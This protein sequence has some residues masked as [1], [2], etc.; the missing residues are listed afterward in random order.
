MEIN[1][2]DQILQTSDVNINDAQIPTGHLSFTGDKNHMQDMFGFFPCGKVTCQIFERMDQLKPTDIGII[3]NILK[4]LVNAGLALGEVIFDRKL[5]EF[6]TEASQYFWFTVIRKLL[7]KKDTEEYSQLI[8]YLND[9][10]DSENDDHEKLVRTTKLYLAV[11][12]R[13]PAAVRDII[14]KYPARTDYITYIQAM[15][16]VIFPRAAYDE[17][18]FLITPVTLALKHQDEEMV[19]IFC[20]LNHF[21][22]KKKVTNQGEE[23]WCWGMQPL[24][25]RKI[26]GFCRRRKL[27]LC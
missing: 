23:A 6:C 19:N 18:P 5:G 20:K 16:G 15:P 24:V 21:I 3:T 7:I 9:T 27:S 2:I 12:T 4:L 13:D 22:S 14:E 8:R 10:L 25:K 11:E 26:S 1:K 17:E